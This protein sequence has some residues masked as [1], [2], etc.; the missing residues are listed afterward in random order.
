[1]RWVGGYALTACALTASCIDPQ[2]ND[3]EEVVDTHVAVVVPTN[4]ANL[5]PVCNETSITVQ[6]PNGTWTAG[7]YALAMVVDGVP[8]QC[9][10]QVADPPAFV[11]G[12]CSATDTTLNLAPVCPLTPVCARAGVCDYILSTFDCS[13]DRFTIALTIGVPSGFVG[14][15]QPH[16]VGQLSLDLSLDGSTLMNETIAPTQTT[17]EPNGAGCGTCTN[18]SATL[19][20][21][22]G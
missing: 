14:D 22:G 12:T 15:A 16:V 7:T 13:S 17:T 5:A 18:A 9:T 2:S 3:C 11:Q 1:M 20:I 10:M 21:A 19:S 4:D 6:S 8:Q